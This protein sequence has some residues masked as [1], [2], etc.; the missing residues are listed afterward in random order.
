MTKISILIIVLSILALA[1]TTKTLH[2]DDH[3][4]LWPFTVDEV[5]L[6]CQDDAW[7]AVWVEHNG[8]RYGM[9]GSGKTY[10]RDHFPDVTRNADTILTAW[11]QSN[12]VGWIIREGF[13]LCGWN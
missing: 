3:G 6:V 2:R 11:G 8:W 10:L 1:C 4:A 9:N 5:T 12:G 13:K 7:K